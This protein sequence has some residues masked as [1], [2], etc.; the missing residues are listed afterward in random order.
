MQ[1]FYFEYC[2]NY[3][4]N[5]RQVSVYYQKKKLKCRILTKNEV[6]FNAYYRKIKT[7]PKFLLNSTKPNVLMLHGTFL[8]LVV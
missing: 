4:A 7:H 8:W 3:N 5:E 2:K 6:N 1:R